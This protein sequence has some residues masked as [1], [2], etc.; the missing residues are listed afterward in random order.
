MWSDQVDI[1]IQKFEYFCLNWSLLECL[2]IFNVTKKKIILVYMH[3]KKRKKK[4]NALKASCEL[5]C[6]CFK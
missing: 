2:N 5:H 4:G 1:M 6:H 3:G